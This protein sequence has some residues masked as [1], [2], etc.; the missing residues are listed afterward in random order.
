MQYLWG[1]GSR[2]CISLMIHTFVLTHLARLSRHCRHFG[3]TLKHN[4]L[5]IVIRKGIGVV[6]LELV[7]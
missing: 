6:H 7:L 4:A 5:D 1:C 2:G 3:S